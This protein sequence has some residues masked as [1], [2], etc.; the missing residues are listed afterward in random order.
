MSVRYTESF[1]AVLRVAEK[2]FLVDAAITD[3]MVQ[4][5]RKDKG[6]KDTSR[7][8]KV[9]GRRGK[10][11]EVQRLWGVLYGGDASIASRSSKGLGRMLAVIMTACSV[12][13]LTVSEAKTEIVCLRIKGGGKVLFTINA[14]GQEYKKKIKFVYLGGAITADR[15]LSIDITRRLQRVWA[16]FQPYKMEIYDHPALTVEGVVAESPGDRDTTQRLHDVEPEQACRRQA[17]TGS[18]RHA[19]PMPRMAETKAGRPPPIVPRRA[20][21]DSFREHTG[22]SAQTEDIVR[23]IRSTYGGGA[24]ATEGNVWG[25]CC[26]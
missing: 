17:T 5:Q 8:G 20:C 24:S 26:G 10:E 1:A 4:L 11:E 16:S 21:Q 9:D 23:R 7:T 22:N 2:R 19:P 14:A 3:D 15:D 12:L 25:T 6:E 18:P 13:G